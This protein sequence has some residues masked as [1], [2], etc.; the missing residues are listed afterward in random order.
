MA[1]SAG[2]PVAR[3]CDMGVRIRGNIWSALSVAVVSIGFVLV[4]A[5]HAV[6]AQEFGPVVAPDV[7]AER[8]E[9]GKQRED[10]DA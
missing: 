2:K 10:T 7:N 1:F 5:P 6:P 8:A 3:W 4:F 9:L